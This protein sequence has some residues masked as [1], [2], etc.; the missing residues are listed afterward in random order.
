MLEALITIAYAISL[1]F[2]PAA[3]VEAHPNRHCQDLAV[4][5]AE[6][7][8]EGLITEFEMADMLN[9]CEEVKVW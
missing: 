8:E 3:P 5:L 1:L 6:A 9:G 7:V 4:T 2:V